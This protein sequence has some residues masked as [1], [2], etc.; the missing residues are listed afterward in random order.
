[1]LDNMNRLVCQS[2]FIE[3]RDVPETEGQRENR[4]GS[5]RIEQKLETPTQTGIFA[6]EMIDQIGRK[7]DDEEDRR[8]IHQNEMLEHVSGEK[9]VLSNLIERRPD[10]E[11]GK[12]QAEIEAYDPPGPNLCMLDP[13]GPDPQ[14]IQPSGQEK[15]DQK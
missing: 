11:I 4:A 14:R 3:R 6:E 1:M 10:G 5:D 12:D 13:E 8:D 7:P 9:V 15:P 2:C